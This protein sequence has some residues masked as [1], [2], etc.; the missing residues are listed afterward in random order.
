MKFSN[1][2]RYFDTISVSDG[3]T[4]RY[5]FK[6]QPG[7][8]ESSSP[9]GNTSKRRVLSL[10]STLSIPVRRCVTLMGETWLIGDSTND[11]LYD[12]VLRTGYWMR[13][14]SGLVTVQTPGAGVLNSGGTAVH[15]L[16]EYLKDTVDP[17]TSAE[18][19][20][21]YVYSF[22]T[23]ET[24]AK[25]YILRSGSD[26]LHVRSVYRDLG[27]FQV[28]VADLL[29]AGAAVTATFTTSTYAP[30]T[31]SYSTI[32]T[33]APAL[34]VER[35]KLYELQTPADQTYAAGD[36]SLLV[37]KSSITPTPGQRLTIASEPWLVRQVTSYNDAWLLH[38][39]RA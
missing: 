34:L 20:P 22:S 16:R 28:A 10:A 5:L 8:F 26:L 7:A 19:D 15:A 39:R 2:S 11:G 25:G 37:A 32:N 33:A 3:Y 21:Q 29:G 23:Y 6:G 35:A 12:T 17:S 13:K 4:G 36:S 9:E 14:S 31:D 27:G 18:Y 1:V 24:V 30:S 38:M